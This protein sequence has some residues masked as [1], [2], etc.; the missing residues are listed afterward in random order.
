MSSERNSSTEFAETNKQISAD[1]GVDHAKLAPD[2]DGPEHA[3]SPPFDNS[4]EERNQ[5]IVKELERGRNHCLREL[6][7]EIQ[8]I[9]RI[10]DQHTIGQLNVINHLHELQQSATDAEARIE[11]LKTVYIP[12][13]KRKDIDS[14]IIHL[15]QLAS[16]TPFLDA[17]KSQQLTQLDSPPKD[18][19]HLRELNY[20][21]TRL[22]RMIFLIGYTTIME[23]LNG[24]IRVS[25]AGYALPFHPMFEDEIESVEDRQRILQL[26]S[27]KP[28]DIQGGLVD[29]SRGIVLCYPIAFWDRLVR[30][31]IVILLFLLSFALIWWF[32]DILSHSSDLL[33]TL[34]MDKAKPPQPNLLSIYWT[35]LLLGIF[36]HLLVAGAKQTQAEFRQFPMPLQDWGYYLSART[37]TFMYKMALAFLVFVAMYLSLKG[38]MKLFDAFLIGYSFDSVVE[39]V[40]ASMEKSANTKLAAYTEKLGVGG[41]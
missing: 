33:T 8:E 24:W 32:S 13:L 30:H 28:G 26:F 6:R 38:E 4:R 34:G 9:V 5:E 25:R 16:N 18:Q 2:D 22:M 12:R 40:G 35:A 11:K 37:S 19:D 3:V 17:R 29:L 31:L 21:K 27:L 41:K 23:R 36:A 20:L 39:L 10:I 15:W 7:V 1:A 14:E